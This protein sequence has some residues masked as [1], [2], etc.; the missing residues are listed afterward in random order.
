MLTD[1]NGD[2]N[3]KFKA[4]EEYD[5]NLVVA[6]QIMADEEAEEAACCGYTR[7]QQEIEAALGNAPSL[8][9]EQPK[10]QLDKFL[11]TVTSQPSS[12][13][14]ILGTELTSQNVYGAVPNTTSGETTKKPIT[15]TQPKPENAHEMEEAEK[16][17]VVTVEET[18]PP[19]QT[20]TVVKECEESDYVAEIGDEIS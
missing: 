5:S 12:R 9:T 4:L 18:P 15:S 13:E 3:P 14:Y 2:D 19:P 16:P 10:S 6:I 20:T 17:T 1:Y 8:P 7:R 11:E